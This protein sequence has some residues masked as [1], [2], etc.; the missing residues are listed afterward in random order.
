M[1]SR[2]KSLFRSAALR[3]QTQGISYITERTL[4]NTSNNAFVLSTSVTKKE[5]CA[6]YNSGCWNA[7]RRVL[8]RSSGCWSGRSPSS[9]AVKAVRSST[10]EDRTSVDIAFACRRVWCNTASP[11]RE[12]TG[13]GTTKHT[14]GRP[15]SCTRILWCRDYA[16]RRVCCRY[17]RLWR[18]GKMNGSPCI[19][20]YCCA[21]IATVH[22][23]PHSF[24]PQNAATIG[25]HQQF[26][27]GIPSPERSVTFGSCLRSHP[28]T[29]WILEVNIDSLPFM[30][31]GWHQ[32]A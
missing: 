26:H 27:Q 22:P 8:E 7:T 12:R 28:P 17:W 24:T 14:Q 29:I 16:T 23:R 25:V 6:S 13:E 19:Y 9:R 18:K 2:R 20:T 11:Q 30:L 3:D 10:N 21:L 5:V 1:F 15:S 32:Q 31:R 4:S